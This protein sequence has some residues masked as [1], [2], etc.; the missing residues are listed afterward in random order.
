MI[1]LVG[2]RLD[3]GG[4]DDAAALQEGVLDRIVRDQRLAGPRGR[5]HQDRSPG[6]DSLD[7]PLLKGI[8]ALSP[9][10]RC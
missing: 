3:G 9:E 4:V 2:E 5:R 6:V 1:L 7:R 10:R 8:E